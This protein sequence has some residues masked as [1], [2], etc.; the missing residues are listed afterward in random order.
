M[1][2]MTYTVAGLLTRTQTRLETRRDHAKNGTKV[3]IHLVLVKKK[4]L[5]FN[6]LSLIAE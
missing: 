6:S 4:K 1:I 3:K 5:I 2:N